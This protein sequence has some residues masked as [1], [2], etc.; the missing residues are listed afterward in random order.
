MILCEG[1]AVDSPGD[2]QVVRI[3]NSSAQRNPWTTR[4]KA[5]GPFGACVVNVIGVGIIRTMQIA[6][7]ENDRAISR[8]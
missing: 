5:V 7:A 3:T 1:L 6:P 8:S 4:T 2:M